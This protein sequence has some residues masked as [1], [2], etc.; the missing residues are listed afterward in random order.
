MT[1]STFTP[2][3]TRSAS[4]GPTNISDELPQALSMS[5]AEL[6][7]LAA[8]WRLHDLNE[9]ARG[10][11]IARALEWLADYREPKPRT[12]LEELGARL[13]DW[14]GMGL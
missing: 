3:L 10:E 4:N 14:M 6:R 11:R 5:S 13:S 9:P 1:S 2:L 7:I 8:Q 12:R